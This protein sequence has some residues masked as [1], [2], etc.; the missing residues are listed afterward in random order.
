MKHIHFKNKKIFYNT[1]GK[2]LPVILIHGFA[3]DSDVWQYQV[4]ELQKKVYTI[5]PDLPGSG[6]SE[7]IEGTIQI[8]DYADV[9]K[10][11]T[12][13]EC[14]HYNFTT[15][16]VIGHSMG[17][18]IALAFAEKY[19]ELLNGLGLFHS[20][21]YA[22]DDAKKEARKKGIDF[23][24]NNS[25]EL[26]LRST[27]PNLFSLKTKDESSEMIEDFINL[28]KKNTPQSL[29][30]YYNAMMQRPDR[31]SILKNITSPV[32][33]VIGKND[34]AVSLQSSLQQCY[35]PSI[36]HIHILQNSAHMGLWE[37]KAASNIIL[38]QFLSAILV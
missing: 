22:D 27:A 25:V 26:F 11:I 10:A 38:Q 32:L 31:I 2:G 23:I 35:L 17:G 4:N 36:S 21:A 6:S 37:E 18:Y 24:K 14:N 13:A 29:I 16:T 30:Q 15:F 28:Y 34:K 9:V 33:F 1:G 8:E 5:I 19:P 7:M 12:D 3:E 20:T